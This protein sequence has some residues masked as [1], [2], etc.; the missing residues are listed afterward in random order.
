MRQTWVGANQGT[1][2]RK[3]R[4]SVLIVCPGSP[5]I[6][7]KSA[8]PH[9]ACCLWI[10]F[11]VRVTCH[12]FTVQPP[13]RNRTA[14][15]SMFTRSHSA[16]QIL[17]FVSFSESTFS[18]CESHLIAPV[19][20]ISIAW[21]YQ[22]SAPLINT[23]HPFVSKSFNCNLSWQRNKWLV[24]VGLFHNGGVWRQVRNDAVL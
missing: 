14:R 13:L 11:K 16:L 5:H 9:Q 17:V 3:R 1:L 18:R 15:L 21:N 24:P 22:H 8:A 2:P 19:N 12:V 7:E 4:Q 23:V 10:E 6:P 20:N